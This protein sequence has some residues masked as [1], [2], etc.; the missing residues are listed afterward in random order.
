[1]RQQWAQGV[2]SLSSRSFVENE[3]KHPRWISTPWILERGI[4][5]HSFSDPQ[6]LWKAVRW[7]FKF[8]CFS[9]LA[10]GPTSEQPDFPG[11]PPASWWGQRMH[12]TWSKRRH[13]SRLLLITSHF[14]FQYNYCMYF[15]PPDDITNAVSKKFVRGS[16]LKILAWRTTHLEKRSRQHTSP[17]SSLSSP[18]SS[19]LFNFFMCVHMVHMI[20][21]PSH[22][23][24]K[25]VN[26]TFYGIS[27]MQVTTMF[28]KASAQSCFHLELVEI[29]IPVCSYISTTN[30]SWHQVKL[31]NDSLWEHLDVCISS[32]FLASS[33][34]LHWIY[35]YIHIRP[36]DQLRPWEF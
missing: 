9:G 1:M 2:A 15:L 23:H 18:F 8:P 5:A 12:A 11:Q 7:H 30:V 36:S 32:I 24:V 20:S 3:N 27:C 6:N 10:T 21:L 22:C 26:I 4:V 16:N 31:Q 29:G 17:C 33:D 14:W 28:G 34:F 13:K 25:H 35:L 19:S